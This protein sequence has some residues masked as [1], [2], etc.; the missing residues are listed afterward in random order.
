MYY[1]EKY[2]PSSRQWE[3]IKRYRKYLVSM[4]V[5]LDRT[6]IANPGCSF[7]LAGKK[8]NGERWVSSGHESFERAQARE[9]LRK[10]LRRVKV[11][12]T[13]LRHCSRSGMYR[14]IGVLLV[15]KEW[16]R[17]LSCR[18]ASALGWGHN[19]RYEGVSVSGCG[20]D[21][22]FHLVYELSHLLFGD[23]YRIR[24]QWI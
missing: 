12:N 20:M 18:V 5:T 2:N 16:T 17:D 15:K 1:I 7:R 22:G 8:E 21:M 11:L 13:V 6:V 4:R 10:L 19:S 14:V 9:D 24:N 3:V 23:G